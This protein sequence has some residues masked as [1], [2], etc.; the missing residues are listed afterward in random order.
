MTASTLPML[1][2]ADLDHLF[3][4]L[5]EI[6]W[7]FFAEKRIFITGGSG[8][9][10]KWL[11]SALLDTDR[12]MSLNCQIELLTRSPQAFA[13]AIPQLARA[14]NVT[15]RQG[16]V[17]TFAFPSDPFD[18]VIHGA[19][20]VAIQNSPIETFSTCV[21]GTKH[22]LDFSR[23]C[24]AKDFLLTSSGA[25]YGRHPFTAGGLSE[26]YS[27][28][29]DPTLATSA[30]GEGKRVSEW[31]ACAH[32]AETGLRVKIARIYAQVGPYLPLDKHF[33][34]GN[35]IN[36]VLADREIVIRGDGTP[37]RSYLHAADTT[38]CLLAMLVRGAPGRAWNVGSEV[39]LSIC[40]LA[41]RVANL[42]GSRRGIQVLT[43]VDPN[44]TAE[45]YVPNIDRAKKEL[46]LS[47]P[48][49]IDNAIIRTA[50][51][52]IESNLVKK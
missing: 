51:W 23:I 43:K 3:A 2:Q 6:D 8:F 16:D 15:L 30:Y 33:A 31:L 26:D 17:R 35:F 52:I 18:I 40:E 21:E 9:L 25:V 10:G 14:K 39:G 48:I 11:L 36:D 42:L 37:V 4:G 32:A 34:I 38:R 13:E 27:G 47:T 7:G 19:T 50:Q 28:G 29:P 12:R 5:S 20:D 24:G 1:P 41:E 22:I 44:C 45:Y 46:K 49:M